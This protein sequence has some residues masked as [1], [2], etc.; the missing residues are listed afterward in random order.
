[1]NT[2]FF[3]SISK[4]FLAPTL[5]L[6]LILLVGL[7][8]FLITNNKKSI[9]QTMDDKSGAMANLMSQ[10]SVPSY[11]N[12]D[13]IALEQLVKQMIADPEVEFA[14]F[15]DVQKKPV[16]KASE[17]K[18]A[19]ANIKVYERDVSGEDKK[20]LGTLRIGYSTKTLQVNLRNNILSVIIGISI[21]LA[22]MSFGLT[23]MV[24]KIIVQRVQETVAMLKNIAEGEGDLTQR[25]KVTSQ[26]EL[27]ELATYF[28]KFVSNIEKIIASVKSSAGNV[29]TTTSR[30]KSTADILS[31]VAN[32][33]IEQTTQAASAANQMESAISETSKNAGMAADSAKRSSEFAIQG[34]RVVEATV[35]SMQNIANRVDTTA[36]T[37]EALGKSS[38]QI[39]EIVS[40]IKEI[41][42]QTNLLAL[43]AAIEA[44]RAGEQGRGFAVVADEVRKLAERTTNATGEIAEMIEKIQIDTKNSVDAMRQGRAEV[45]SGVQ[46]AEDAKK[47]LTQIVS[48]SEQCLNWVQMIANATGEQSKAISHISSTM[49]KITGLS[50][51][52]QDE[53]AKINT[54]A[55]EMTTMANS[56]NSSVS[57][58]KTGVSTI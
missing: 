39:S 48:A 27:G 1:M 6:T 37:V 16:T 19:S 11:Q 3:N 7:G 13:Y 12:F 24:R 41:A 51:S 34:N 14:V 33:G 10:V 36:G 52:S 49:N 57:L 55:H 4:K 35:T 15:Y 5:L 29:D 40:V 20:V 58:F 9:E 26:D 42:S 44:A 38:D 21:A 45:E 50:D 46:Q 23:M 56:L 32:Q 28:N 18:Q 8:A 54:I 22:L 30:L 2:S 53:S 31:K 47:S 25:L 17:E 43:N